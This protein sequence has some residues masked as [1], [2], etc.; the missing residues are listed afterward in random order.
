LR[1]YNYD[2]TAIAEDARMSGAY[3]DVLDD[4]DLDDLD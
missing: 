1:D 4:D 2:F 3:K